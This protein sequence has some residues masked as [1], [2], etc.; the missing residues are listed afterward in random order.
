[1]LADPAGQKDA[2]DPFMMGGRDEEMGGGGGGGHAEEE[3]DDE[4]TVFAGFD[5]ENK[6]TSNKN[7][8]TKGGSTSGEGL[9][10]DAERKVWENKNKA[11]Y[12]AF[13]SR[14]S[15]GPWDLRAGAFRSPASLARIR[16]QAERVFS[17]SLSS[18]LFASPS[19]QRF[20]RHTDSMFAD[21]STSFQK[22][23]VGAAVADLRTSL[24][25]W[26]R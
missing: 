12:G 19:M 23:A 18:S 8:A 26:F 2:G 17:D 5:K 24:F 22:S 13:G 3:E 7:A 21:I 9:S 16:S 1:M 10:W 15:G 14:S 6:P 4:F 20:K 25:S 11:Q